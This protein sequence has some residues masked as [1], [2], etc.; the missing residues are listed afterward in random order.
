MLEI[1]HKDDG[2]NGKFYIGEEAHYLAEMTYTWAGNDKIIID[3]TTVED[4]LR[5]E[6]VGRK[7]LDNLVEFARQKKIFVIPLCPFAKSVFDK[8]QSIHDIL[9]S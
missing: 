4:E 9:F 7:L 6:G 5:G 8:D 3:H 1:K 2:K